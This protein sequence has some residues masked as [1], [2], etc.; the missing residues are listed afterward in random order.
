[1]STKD[2]LYSVVFADNHDQPYEITREDLENAD[3]IRVSEDS[4]HLL[5]SHQSHLIQVL[6][7]DYASKEFLLR[8][9]GRDISVKLRDEVESRIHVMGFDVSRNHVKLNLISSPMPGMVLKILVHEGETVKEG[10]PVIVLE[11]MKMEN[12]LS[13][14]L[15]GVVSKITV[16]ETQNVDKNQLLVEIV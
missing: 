15:D 10:Q 3:I 7:A 4:I 6:K 14:P 16:I 13:A 1:M 8:I 12:V 5:E 9:N 2:I 11:A